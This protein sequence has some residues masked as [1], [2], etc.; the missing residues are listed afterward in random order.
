MTM[1]TF[2]P[3]NSFLK[4]AEC[5]D[6]RRL[7]KQ[8]VEV[9]QILIAL[10]ENRGWVHHPATLMWAGHEKSLAAYGLA[11]CVHCQKRGIADNVGFEKFFWGIFREN[12]RKQWRQKPWWLGHEP[13]HKAHRSNLLRKDPVHYGQFFDDPPDL[14]YLWPDM[15]KKKF[16]VLKT[17]PGTK[18]VKI[19]EYI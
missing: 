10:I 14:P 17:K 9:K 19:K 1:Q 3:H 2:L 5:L 4:S 16:Y 6:N 8:R 12:L 7:N 13:F 11:C 15:E 18:T